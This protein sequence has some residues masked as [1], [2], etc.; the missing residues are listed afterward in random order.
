MGFGTKWLSWMEGCIFSSSMFVIINGSI[1]KDFKVEKGLCQGD[2]LSPFLFVLATKV[3]TVLMRKAISNDD[4]RGFMIN[5]EENVKMLQYAD[6]TVI[7]AEGDIANLWSMKEILR[8]FEMMSGLWVNFNKSNIYGVNVFEGFIE[9]AHTFLSCKLDML[10]CKFLGVKVGGNPRKLAMWK[11]LILL[12]KRRLVAW[13]GNLGYQSKFLWNGRDVK[14]PIHWV[15]WDTVCKLRE[16]GGLGVKNVGVMNV[17]LLSKW[18]W[19]I[20]VEEEAVWRGILVSRYGNIKLKVLIGDV[21]V[22]EKSDSIWWRDILTSD[23]Y[24]ALLNQ[25]F[26]GAISCKYNRLGIFRRL[27]GSGRKPASLVSSAAALCFS[28][29]NYAM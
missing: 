12:L 10:L 13:K 5:E 6:D 28:G 7:L 11:D 24:A 3:L 17:A 15:N 29:R 2:P 23:N 20:L 1:T 18:K 22:V 4:F 21:S 8:G 25:N 26:S 14:R 9:A 16:E 27:A 19:R